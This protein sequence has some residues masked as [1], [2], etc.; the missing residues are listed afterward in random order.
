MLKSS[1]L[2]ENCEN[3]HF[4]NAILSFWRKTLWAIFFFRFNTWHGKLLWEKI[5]S[6]Q[7]SYFEK[8]VIVMDCLYYLIYEQKWQRR[9]DYVLLLARLC[10]QSGGVAIHGNCKYT[11]RTND[12]KRQLC[13]RIF[14]LK[15]S[16]LQPRDIFWQPRKGLHA[17]WFPPE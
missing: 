8:D 16:Y 2:L 4:F 12:I 9:N 11:A 1:W 17:Q 5:F 13:G 14:K 7:S 3:T 10:C 15:S 6:K